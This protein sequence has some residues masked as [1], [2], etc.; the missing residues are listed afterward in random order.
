MR[1]RKSESQKRKQQRF[2]QTTERVGR[3]KRLPAMQI[4]LLERVRLQKAVI[5]AVVAVAVA[6]VQVQNRAAAVGKVINLRF[7]MVWEKRQA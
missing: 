6:A 5:V 7:C 4:N 3:R 2:R 1:S